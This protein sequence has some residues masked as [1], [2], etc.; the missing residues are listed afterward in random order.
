VVDIRFV[1]DPPNNRVHM[2]AVDEDNPSVDVT[3]CGESPGGI[4]GEW[5]DLVR[6]RAG[7]YPV[8]I[9]DVCTKCFPNLK[10]FIHEERPLAVLDF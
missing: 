10:Q 9:V 1:V 2:L 7:F 4:E 6:D 3:V 5:T 8:P